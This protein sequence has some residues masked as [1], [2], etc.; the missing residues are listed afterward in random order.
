MATFEFKINGNPNN[1]LL[2]KVK[3]IVNAGY[4]GRN[5]EEVQKHIDELKEKGIPGPDEIPT[6]FPKFRDRLTQAE[7]VEALDEKGH[8]GEAEYVLLCAGNEIYVAAGSDHTDRLV[9]QTSIPKAKQVYPNFISK[10]VWKLSEVRDHFDQIILRGV[11]VNNGIESV[12]QEVPL[13]ALLSP[14][15]LFALVNEIVTDT[16]GLA[17]FSG[18]VGTLVD[19]DCTPV[20]RTELDDPVLGRKLS[21]SYRMKTIDSWFKGK[22]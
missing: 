6:Y 3:K 17:I 18:T 15:E 12:F 2:F 22:L 13:S 11:V 21:C 4:T 9:E 8:T 7:E 5:Q 10:D 14:D 20:F 16:E 1:I 19:L